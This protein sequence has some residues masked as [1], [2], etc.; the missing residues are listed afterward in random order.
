MVV[1]RVRRELDALV[2]ELLAPLL[3]A[4]PRPGGWR[5]VGWDVEQGIS[6]S[7]GRGDVVLLVEL[8]PRDETRDC[9]S[10]TSRFNV[11]ARRAFDA[12]E[13]LTDDERRAVDQLVGL[14]AEREREMPHR[15]RP[16]TASRV[17]VREIEVDRVLMPEGRGHYYVNPY[18][19]C[20]IGCAF[21]Y[22]AERADMS[23][24]LEGLPAVPWGRYVDVKINAAE[25]LRRELKEH[26]PGVVRMSPILTDPYQPLERRYRITR[27]CLEALLEMGF[28]PC[29]LTRAALV[30]EDV[31]L[32]ARFPR[33]AVGLS[34]PTDDDRV[35]AS[36]EP[37]ADCIDDR[38]AAL[39]R[40]HAAGIQTFG[41][42]QPVLPMDVERLVARMAPL[43]SAVRIDRM[44]QMARALPLYEAAG[45]VDAAGDR[46]FAETIAKLRDGFQG[47]GVAVDDLDDLAGLVR[48]AARS[49]PSTQ[50]LRP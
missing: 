46:F 17:A 10:R 8:E 5:L 31:A 4:H 9:Y 50:P 23:R 28:T 1:Q 6:I 33:A 2:G 11:C 35:R 25:V 24:A 22:V 13:S 34:I 30:A 47:K 20:M 32:L 29:V 7:L 26:P 15:D 48:G 38:F 37:G 12:G 49:R 21:C 39:E 14:L 41:A 45:R 43:V 19:G 27:A 42:V 18:V 36:F 40:C 16:A 3:A 44:H